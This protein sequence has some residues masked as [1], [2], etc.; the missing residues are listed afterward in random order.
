MLFYALIFYSPWP[1]ISTNWVAVLVHMNEKEMM[2][3]IDLNKKVTQKQAPIII[4]KNKPNP[5]IIAETL[6]KLYEQGVRV[7]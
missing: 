6:K 7:K 1:L 2:G 3:G 5:K 4:E